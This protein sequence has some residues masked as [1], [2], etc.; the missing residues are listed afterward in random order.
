MRNREFTQ[1]TDK[2]ITERKKMYDEAEE[3]G[4]DLMAFD[5][6]SEE[7]DERKDVHKAI[8]FLGTGRQIPKE[9][10]DRLIKRKQQREEI[11]GEKLQT[12]N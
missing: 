10:R 12:H 2:E 9:I 4:I 6:E 3:L 11:Q 1:P 8:F 7:N 5:G